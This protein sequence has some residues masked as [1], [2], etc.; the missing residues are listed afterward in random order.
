MFR[1]YKLLTNEKGEIV[2]KTPVARCGSLKV[3]LSHAKV[4]SN[5]WPMGVYKI[6]DD[7]TEVRVH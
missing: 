1:V 2:H 7:G 4:W 5:G 3:A 6:N